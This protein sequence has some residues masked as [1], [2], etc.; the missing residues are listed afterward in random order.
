MNICPNCGQSNAFESRFCRF[1]GFLLTQP[2]QETPPGR[3]YLWKTD[4]FD[5]REQKPGPANTSEHVRGRTVADYSAPLSNIQPLGNPYPAVGYRCPRCGTN[6]LP[7]TER[8]VS[9]AGWIVFAVLLVATLLFCWI[10]LL[11]R[12]DVR[13]CP[14]CGFRLN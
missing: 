7:V 8:R 10:G 1:C 6:A 4:E 3:P 5:L 2:S 11:L 13:V 12:E 9:S 14:V